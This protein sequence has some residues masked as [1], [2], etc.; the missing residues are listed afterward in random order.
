[1]SE[2]KEFV[3]PGFRL[4]WVWF[5]ALL[6]RGFS[7]RSWS[8]RHSAD[9]AVIYDGDSKKEQPSSFLL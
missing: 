5:S 2:V 7:V 6:D 8:L 3:E 9:D 4:C 1:M